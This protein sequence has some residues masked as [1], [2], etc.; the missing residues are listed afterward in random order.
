MDHFII[1]MYW[2]IAVDNFLYGRINLE[3]FMRVLRGKPISK[4]AIGK[5]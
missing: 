4:F 5:M 3:S 1:S 2:A